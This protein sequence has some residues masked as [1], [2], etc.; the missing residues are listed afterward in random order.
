ME[1]AMENDIV[2]LFNPFLSLMVMNPAEALA[3]V[4]LL[5]VVVG[6]LLAVFKIVPVRS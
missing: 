4:F 6:I 2:P 5:G 1:A 3:V